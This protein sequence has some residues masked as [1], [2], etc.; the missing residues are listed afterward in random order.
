MRVLTFLG[1]RPEII[2]LSRIIPLLQQHC[3]HTLVHT[4]QNYD[5]S[6]SGQFLAELGYEPGPVYWL[7]AQ[8]SLGQ[9]MA[10]IFE[11]L[12]MAILKAKPD[13]F[14]VLGDTNSSLGAIVA[15]RMGIPV[16]H[17]EAGNRCFDDLSP[18]EVNRKI[19]DHTSD[20]HLCYTEHSRRNLLAE[21]VHLSRV[22]VVGNPIKEVQNY[23]WPNA[24]NDFPSWI[25][26]LFNRLGVKKGNYLLSTFH[27]QEN[28][29]PPARLKSIV[30]GLVACHQRFG[31]PV[32]A[33][34]HPRT[35][36]RLTA[37]YGAGLPKE[38]QFLEPLGFLDFLALE[39]HARL[40]L[41]DSGTIQEEAA[42]LG[43]GCVVLRDSTERPEVV[44][45][46][47]SFLAGA[48]SAIIL[49]G[50]EMM[51]GRKTGTCAP[52]EE[53][54]RPNVAQTICNIVLGQLP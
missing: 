34:T 7:N 31:C 48:D 38:V 28:V 49:A 50:A 22:H 14:L 27:R 15:K 19:I 32:L 4:G 8:G 3:E 35:R 10:K 1:T 16:F 2:R 23:Y 20:V 52:P 6:L 25:E 5:H 30:E 33:S 46:G 47:C 45:R 44:E 54:L 26:V 11:G 17:L 24:E 12:E 53:Y 40:I 36:K 13:R 21:G 51:L 43:I 39:K 42:I 9:Q 41:S 29:D 18:E 37:L